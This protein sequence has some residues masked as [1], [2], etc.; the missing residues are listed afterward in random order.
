MIYQRFSISL[1]AVA[2]VGDNVLYQAVCDSTPDEGRG[3]GQDASGCDSAIGFKHKV[4]D[5]GVRLDLPPNSPD[6][7]F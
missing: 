3:Y 7:I 4:I 1:P 5:A 2:G 6:C